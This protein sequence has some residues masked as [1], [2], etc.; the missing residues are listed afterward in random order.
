MLRYGVV[1]GIKKGY[2]KVFLE[3]DG[4]VT[5]W[6][7]V[8]VRKSL[9][10]KESF[11]LEVNEHVVCLM[12][13]KCNEGVCLGAIPNTE[14]LPD[15]GEGPGK[16]RKKFADGT[17]IEY[18][19]IAHRLTVDVKGELN[20]KTTGKASIEAA[21]DVEVST[22]G[23]VKANAA[24]KAE[25]TAPDIELTGSVKITGAVQVIGALSAGA[26]S[27]VAGAGGGSGAIEVQ[28][29]FSVQGTIQ[30]TGQIEGS[31]VKAG[32]ITLLSHKHTAPSGGGATSPAIP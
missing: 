24:V 23:N 1:S 10:D 13:E 32:A 28:G 22:Q 25:V 5:D 14:D 8:L 12:D 9:T 2:V 29:D 27:T 16:F 26:I 4:I 31:D 20:A 7:P 18:D 15:D 30:A 6:L 21:G 19:R 3:Q 17:I 11:Q